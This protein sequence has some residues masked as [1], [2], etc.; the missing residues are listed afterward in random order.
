M[1]HTAVNMHD[2]HVWANQTMFGRL[3]EL[4]EVYNQE[5]Q[6]V[7]PTVSKVMAHIYLTDLCWFDILSGASMAEALSVGHGPL[8]EQTESKSIGELEALYAQLAEK[9]RAYFSQQP[10]LE[11]TL[12]LDN[13][14]AGIRDT[15]VT[16]IILQV[17]NHG[18]YHRG[19]IT[20]MLRQMGHASVM[21]ELGL[22]WHVGPN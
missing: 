6:S 8:K 1:K 10:D 20:A 22:F 18:T 14:Y 12:T 16:E 15:S 4:P 5:V 7:F 21:T 11:Q 17:V 13:P 3:K 9:Y 2:Y 19:N